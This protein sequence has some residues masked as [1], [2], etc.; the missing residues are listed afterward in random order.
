VCGALPAANQSN[1]S[2]T[3]STQLGHSKDQHHEHIV[4]CEGLKAGGTRRSRSSV[5]SSPD[6]KSSAYVEIAAEEPQ[7]GECVNE[8]RL[9][10]KS[11]GDLKFRLVVLQSPEEQNLG[12]KFILIDWS[13]NSRYLLF[14]RML[15]QYGSD[16]PPTIQ[17]ELYLVSG[18]FLRAVAVSE[19]DKEWQQRECLLYL[20]PA[21]FTLNERVIIEEEIHPYTDPGDEKPRDASCP[22]RKSLWE[23]PIEGLDAPRQLPPN[24]D[25]PRFGKS[26][27]TSVRR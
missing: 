12:N 19:I 8:S 13:P 14:E 16:A 9:F 24:Y 7:A 2:H 17:P 15:F 6:L 22:N 1:A 11:E 27:G 20:R 21:G 18:R 5:I 10:V 4:D 26:Q 3:S 23:V 25:I